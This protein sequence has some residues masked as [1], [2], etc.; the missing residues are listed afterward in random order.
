MNPQKVLAT[1]IGVEGNRVELLI[2]SSPLNLEVSAEQLGFIPHLAQKVEIFVQLFT[3]GDGHA[4]SAKPEMEPFEMTRLPWTGVVEKVSEK[5]DYMLIR[6]DNPQL[7]RK[8]WRGK[9]M[10]H[11]SDC[12]TDVVDR[13]E[14]PWDR[15]WL[16]GSTVE[17]WL[18]WRTVGH[19]S[20]LI[21]LYTK[22]VKLNVDLSRLDGK[23]AL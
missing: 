19:G 12:T 14:D 4:R 1:V 17:F 21:A 7:R 20:E 9:I 13:M 5:G 8:A 11:A 10:A 3:W 6:P 15:F 16:I 23:I 2:D 22:I 18:G